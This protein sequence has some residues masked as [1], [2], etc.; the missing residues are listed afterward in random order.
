MR[1][2]FIFSSDKFDQSSEVDNPQTDY[3]EDLAIYLI[4]K[5]EVMDIET[6]PNPLQEDWGWMIFFAHQGINYELGLGA[7]E[8]EGIE[9]GWLCFLK[10]YRKGIWNRLFGKKNEIDS[11]LLNLIDRIL[12]EDQ[13]I[14]NIKW[15]HEN[16]WANGEIEKYTNRPN[17]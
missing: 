1:N 9:S 16:E 12:R 15:Y 11:E 5:L 4:R 14:N 3:G 10:T 7:Y 2:H 13:E 6:D 17:D 8:D